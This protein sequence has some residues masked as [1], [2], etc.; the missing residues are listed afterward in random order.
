MSAYCTQAQTEARFGTDNISDWASLAAGDSSATKIAR[1]AAGIAVVS[2]EL[3]EVLR[4]VTSYE[5]KLPI[6]TV[7][8]SVADK[9]AIGVGLWLYSF[10][11]TDDHG[12]EGNYMTWLQVRYDKWI[13]EVRAGLRK[14]NI[15]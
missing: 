12:K 6:S 11:A 13:D 9:V 5:G 14:L 7:P 8:D 4:C 3:D 2:D 1:I 10:H 15:T